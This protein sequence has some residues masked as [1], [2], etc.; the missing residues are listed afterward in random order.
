MIRLPPRSTRTYTLV[1]YTT[2]FRS[3]EREIREDE[4]RHAAVLDDVEGG[5][6]DDRRN[7]VGFEM[8]RDQ[9]HGLVANGSKR[10]EDGRFGRSEEHTSELQSLMRSSY[11][12]FCLTKKKRN[13]ISVRA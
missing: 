2:R 10:G 12:V 5:S 4:S 13:N 1:P 9:T 8:P 3:S 7:T 6:D 11:A